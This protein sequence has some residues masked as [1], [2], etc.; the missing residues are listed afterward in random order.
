MIDTVGLEVGCTEELARALLRRRGRL[1]SI[2]DVRDGEILEVW[3]SQEPELEGSWSRKI[4]CRIK[5]NGYHANYERS[6][7]FPGFSLCKFVLGHNV[8][9]LYDFEGA[10]CCFERWLYEQSGVA[11]GGLAPLGQWRVTRL[12]LCYSW[13]V[14]RKGAL[15]L[16]EW[17]KHSSYTRKKA[18]TYETA[19][20]WVGSSYSCKLYHKGSEFEV[21][22]A[23]ALIKAGI[24]GDRVE[25]LA[26]IADRLVRFEVGMRARAL[27]QHF[28][29]KCVLVQDVDSEYRWERLQY[30]LRRWAMG[31]RTEVWE[32]EDC[33]ARIEECYGHS[34]RGAEM[35]VCRLTGFYSLLFRFGPSR[36]KAMLPKSSYYYL[37]GKLKAAGVAL[38][39]IDDVPEDL[40]G[41][42]FD[43]PS[44]RVVNAEDE[45][46]EW[47]V[48]Q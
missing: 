18:A 23:G 6:L 16:I 30:Y 2:D 13:D 14:G 12:D 21:H 38:V 17:A 27:G 42:H 22:D 25:E 19:V 43:V 11:R 4:Q 7:W 5:G 20:M 34:G 36:V 28:D 46:G 48:N 24:P 33:V 3:T 31:L 44:G 40:V 29:K 10:L 35:R 1:R 32:F 26:K 9:L 39:S 47:I 45:Y 41:L 15:S 37:M 8:K